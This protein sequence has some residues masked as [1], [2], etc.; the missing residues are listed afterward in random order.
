MYEA[1]YGSS[2][3][4]HTYGHLTIGHEADIAD[5]PTAHEYATTFFERHYRPSLATVVVAGDVEAEQV[6]AWVGEAYGEWQ[7]PEVALPEIPVEPVQDG[8]RRVALDWPAETP[9][10]LLMGWRMP[11]EQESPADFAALEVI[12]G[13][14]LSDVGRLHQRL[15]LE[16][17]V[18]F[19]VSG[20]RDDFIDGGLFK[21]W[22]DLR[23][24]RALTQMP[25]RMPRRSSRRGRCALR[26]GWCQAR[27]A[28]VS[29]ALQ[30]PLGSGRAG[31][32]GRVAWWSL[33]RGGLDGIEARFA[34]LDA[35]TPDD[36]SAAAKRW[37]VE[38]G[39]T[40]LT[41]TH[42]DKEVTP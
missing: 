16:E 36:V 19:T 18:A 39:L 34:Q 35:L 1:M 15:V 5:M 23:P 27:R 14:L 21:I 41:L 8:L 25:W 10:R 29:H 20:G 17:E 3:G 40:V 28:P 22:V 33:R 26:R 31:R 37:L 13:L 42:Q 30:L 7:E 4:T 11:T 12:E 38:D 32:G 2:F 6:F 24:P 9:P